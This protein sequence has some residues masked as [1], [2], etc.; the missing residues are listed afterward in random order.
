LTEFLKSL[1]TVRLSGAWLTI[2]SFDGVHRGHQ[3]LIRRLVNDAHAA[4]EPAV[5]LTFFPHPSV[6][7]RGIQGPFYL[8]DPTERATLLAGLGVDAVITLEFNLEMAALTAADFM[9]RLHERLA[10]KCL[11]VGNNFALGRK[12]EGNVDILTRLGDELGYQVQVVTPVEVDGVLISSTQIR[13]WLADGEVSQVKN[14]LG[15]WYRISG[16]I[17][18]GDGRGRKIG[19]PTANLELWPQRALPV[20]GVYAVYGLVDGKCWP[21]VANIGTRPTFETQ[22]VLP[23]L[24]VLLLDYDGDL[25]GQEISV[26]FVARLRSEQRFSS[27]EA[28]LAQIEQDKHTAR[29]LL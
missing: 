15:R 9:R 20:N 5:V 6:V 16:A 26:D 10:L 13:T 8:T 2:G 18:H 1:D 28:L 12:R 29:N 25:Y 22:P 4:G 19:I 3:E 23:R 17:I 11:W 27:V 7:L 24:E 14:G 21:G